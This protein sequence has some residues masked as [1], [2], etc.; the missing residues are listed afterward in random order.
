[1]VIR[2]LGAGV[3]F[4][5]PSF[6]H[7]HPLHSN[8]TMSR[9][10]AK[11]LT[12]D[13]FLRQHKAEFDAERL[14]RTLRDQ[15][16]QSYASTL[17]GSL[18]RANGGRITGPS[19]GPSRTSFGNELTPDQQAARD[20]LEVL[21]SP[22]DATPGCKVPDGNKFPSSAFTIRQEFVVSSDGSTAAN[23]TSCLVLLR[24]DLSRFKLASDVVNP[25]D[26]T[27]RQIRTY[28]PGGNVVEWEISSFPLDPAPADLKPL[29]TPVTEIAAIQ[30]A[31]AMFRTVG[32]GMK[33]RYMAAPVE[34]KGRIVAGLFNPQE[35]FP[36]DGAGTPISFKDLS[37][38]E[39]FFT[40]PAI[41]GCDVAWRPMTDDPPGFRRTS[42]VAPTSRVSQLPLPDIWQTQSEPWYNCPS[43]PS[44]IRANLIAPTAATSFDAYTFNDLTFGPDSPMI[45][46]AA[47][48]LV[49][50][51][52]VFTVEVV[53]HIEAI[54]AERTLS[55]ATAQASGGSPDLSARVQS[56]ASTV[57][58]V[59]IGGEGPDVFNSASTMLDKAVSTATNVGSTAKKGVSAA[60]EAI[61][62][63][64][65][66]SEVVGTIAAFF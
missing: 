32:M 16:Y 64:K 56:V 2:P 24:D 45:V 48:G 57:A 20:Y 49:A 62:V 65:D 34:G 36:S 7:H 6:I 23:D 46:F 11:M 22:C 27:F 39:G 53:W 66:I 18:A 5:N 38:M 63:A 60:K 1:M 25:R 8:S 28:A 51:Q 55:F 37:E 61:K 58:P 35:G 54:A 9:K 42:M 14:S 52:D 4:S 31:F 41:D 15:R 59:S 50:S 43:L 40:G 12:R 10:S 29:W 19:S 30:D 47:S 17:A 44:V 3:E 21:V 26:P 33:V 13:E